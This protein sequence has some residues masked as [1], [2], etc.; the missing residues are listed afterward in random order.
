[1]SFPSDYSAQ[2]LPS[3]SSFW[4]DD[5]LRHPMPTYLSQQQ[6]LPFRYGDPY[7]SNMYS[8]S[9]D[10]LHDP[11]PQ[12][13][14][15]QY[16]QQQ[17]R[18]QQY[19]LFPHG[20]SLPAEDFGQQQPLSSPPSMD[21]NFSP[22]SATFSS[23]TTVAAADPHPSAPG[24]SLLL[25]LTPGHV[26]GTNA[27]DSAAFLTSP[28]FLGMELPLL[29]ARNHPF[30]YRSGQQHQHPQYAAPPSHTTTSIAPSL[31][32]NDVY[33]SRMQSHSEDASQAL[34]SMMQVHRDGH[35]RVASAPSG[36]PY[37]T[38]RMPVMDFDDVPP[39]DPTAVDAAAV[40]AAASTEEEE[41]DDD[42]I[43]AAT[44]HAATAA[45]AAAAAFQSRIDQDDPDNTRPHILG[46]RMVKRQLSPPTSANDAPSSSTTSVNPAQPK[47]R[48]GRRVSS[49]KRAKSDVVQP[50]LPAEPGAS[51]RQKHQKRYCCPYDDCNK[52]FTRPFNLHS[53]IRVHTGEKPFICE[54]CYRPFSRSHDLKR[55]VQS[56]HDTV[57]PYQC[58]NCQKRFSR[59]DA[60]HRHIKCDPKCSGPH[61]HDGDCYHKNKPLPADSLSDMFDRAL[62][63]KEAEL[64]RSVSAA[65]SGL[66]S[67]TQ[68]MDPSPVL[69][70]IHTS[71]SSLALHDDAS[72]SMPRA[73]L[74]VDTTS[75]QTQDGI[76][77]TDT[78]QRGS[79]SRFLADEDPLSPRDV[80]W[81]A[82]NSEYSSSGGAAPCAPPPVPLSALLSPTELAQND[83]YEAFRNASS[84]P[85]PARPTSPSPTNVYA[86]LSRNKSATNTLQSAFGR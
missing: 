71:I 49:R 32:F 48:G 30:D 41:Q 8:D 31:T 16:Q 68:G 62:A 53:H 72:S 18:Q 57:K 76:P 75:A 44:K 11:A 6:R 10:L 77:R 82:L 39:L 63:S 85:R 22:M 43:D 73:S 35:L 7:A 51:R 52:A 56:L 23:S 4:Q 45:A 1:M 28:E 86:Y 36:V 14:L 80:L 33:H 54:H 78:L 3:L 69:P 55:H 47:H 40:A 70:P 17:H 46:R 29:R 81:G 42:M 67:P 84:Q 64:A 83:I 5:P 9:R 38:C 66:S 19:G 61:Q 59:S 26:A 65:P 58:C 74:T 60:I 37:L 79:L 2:L 25:A 20:V 12:Q 24:S 34:R 21:H 13:Q 27:A 50:P 15:Y